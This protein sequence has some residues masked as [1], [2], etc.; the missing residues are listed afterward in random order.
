MPITAPTDTGCHCPLRTESG[1]YAEH[2]AACDAETFGDP[3]TT[4]SDGRTTV[5]PAPAGSDTLR[6]R[7]G[8]GSGLASRSG[9]STLVAFMNPRQSRSRRRVS[10]AVE[11]RHHHWIIEAI[12]DLWTAVLPIVTIGFFI[13]LC[14]GYSSP[15]MWATF[16]LGR[17]HP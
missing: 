2:T 7:S 8:E 13:M 10:S 15:H 1:G 11:A 4:S 6:S 16:H 5:Q 17:L 12:S 14:W 3:V 9:H